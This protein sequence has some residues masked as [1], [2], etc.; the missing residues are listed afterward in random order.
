MKDHITICICTYRRPEML[1]ELLSTLRRQE[2]GGRFTYSVVVVDND[3]GRSA[4]DVVS[5]ARAASGLN[6]R[7]AVEPRQNIALARNLAIAES[8]GDFVAFIDDDELPS[9]A[10]LAQL[11]NAC[12]QFRS[13]GVLGPVVPL[14]AATPPRWI[15]R[16][17]FFDRPSH[18]TGTNL[19][20]NATRTGNALIRS[21]VFGGNGAPFR[22]EYGSGGEDK[23]FFR[24]MI[25]RNFR[26]VWCQ[27]ATVYETIPAER[28]KRR[29][30]IKRA[31]LR[32]KI[33]YNQGINVLKSAVAVPFY[34]VSLPFLCL[35]GHHVFMKYL[36]KNCDHIGRL[37]SAAG[38]DVVKEKY[39][40]S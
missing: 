18:R 24:R 5:K 40:G 37:L 13:D 6:V 33:P 2:T 25:E 10:W 17:K 23:D 7:Y 31:L 21:A 36:V 29:V 19:E 35:F 20:W 38:I 14:Y 28:F 8:E 27:E 4:W 16:G 22:E 30:M 39:V 26:F 12:Y 1:M 9:D 32:G 34:T 11:R 15:A 3:S